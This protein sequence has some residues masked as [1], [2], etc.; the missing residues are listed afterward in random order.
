M[1]MGMDMDMDM[2]MGMGMGMG[3]GM[4]MGMD[5]DMDMGTWS[6]TNG[7]NTNGATAEV[8]NFAGLEKGTPWHVW[9]NNVNGSTKF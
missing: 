4:D 5:M 2:D 1:G 9:E 3:T 8:I 6:Q 7:V